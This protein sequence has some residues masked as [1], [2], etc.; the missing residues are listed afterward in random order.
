MQ[1]FFSAAW[2]SDGHSGEEY[3]RTGKEGKKDKNGAVETYIW[4]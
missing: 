3:I 4:K 1:F 2:E